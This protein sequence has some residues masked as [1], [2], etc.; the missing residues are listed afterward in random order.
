M[1]RR[2]KVLIPH[3]HH[4]CRT[5]LLLALSL[6]SP[7]RADEAVLI[8]FN[9]VGFLPHADKRATL[10]APCAEFAVIR[11]ADGAIVFRGHV[12]GPVLNEDTGEQ[13]HTADFS[14]LTRPGE[15]LL[16]VPGVG[17][18]ANFRVAADVF[19]EPFCTVT[20]GMYLWRCGTTVTN[21]H[22]GQTFS[23]Q[24]CHT[25]D[26]WLDY[27]GGGH[28]RMDG[29]Q[30]W[31]DAGDY[32]KYV[33]NA[34]VTVGV[35]FRA[36]EDFGPQLRD[37]RLGIPESGGTLPDFLAELKWEMDWL[38]KMQAPDGSVYHKISTKRFGPFILPEAETEDRFFIPWSS[39]ATADFVAMTAQAA[40]IY[41]PFDPA[42][43]D[44]CL[45]AAWK[46]YRFLKAHP[47]YHRADMTGFR[48]GSYEVGEVELS[49][50][51]TRN[52]RL[53]AA[54]ELWETTGTPDVL[55]DLETLIDATGCQVNRNFDWQDLKDLGLLT[56]LFSERP[57]RN[58]TLVKQ[59][60]N[61]LLAAADEMV[62]N[63]N[64]HGYARPLGSVYYWGCNGG[65]AR[66]T[67]L[68]SAADRLCAQSPPTPESRGA[69]RLVQKP[70]LAPRLAPH[71]TQYRAAYLDAVSYLLGRNCYGRSLVTGVGFRPPMN[72]H[73]RRS[74]GDNIVDP[75]PGYL[76]GGPWPKA[77]DW[78]DIQADARTN[79]IA[80]NWN[81]ALI[82]A[83]AACLAD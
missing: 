67:L 44:R 39:E 63:R 30:G 34:G 46:S 2:L 69:E 82:Y 60:R 15:Y 28:A 76:V 57:G 22:L 25:N 72:P 78:K 71:K 58:P 45:E 66:Q 49:A 24:A 51:G 75:W 17:R 80:I 5:L 36:W 35:M 42:Y 70:H 37:I 54:A 64:R 56:Y 48:T 29:S 83:L 4:R 18:S 79:E 8:R 32:N 41:R 21:T 27:V 1:L 59:V 65:V 68:L 38:L 20:R 7:V 50:N 16:E 73:D 31:H 3:A 11:V 43:A 33:V 14:K 19:L 10:A 23:H 81:A 74:G 40:R 55:R 62:R 61:N 77:T 12:T 53:W 9:S 47:E 13:L 26:A 6:L 52:N